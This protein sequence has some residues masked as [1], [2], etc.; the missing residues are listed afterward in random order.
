M[1][2]SA[3]RVRSSRA[4]ESNLNIAIFSSVFY[5]GFRGGG[6][7]RSLANLVLASPSG[8]RIRVF[9]RDRDFGSKER[10]EV[11]EDG[12]EQFGQAIVHY[13]RERS[14]H[15]WLGA[16][17][18]L[19]G[20]APDVI[21]VNSVWDREFC[22]LPLLLWRV[23]VLP[24]EYFLIAPRGELH[25]GA[26]QL[27]RWRKAVAGPLLAWLLKGPRVIWHATTELEGADIRS[28]APG[29]SVLVSPNLVD[30]PFVAEPPSP[31]TSATLKAVFVGRIAPKKGLLV[32]IQALAMVESPVEFDVWGPIED[33]EYWSACQRASR[34]LPSRVS[35]RYRGSASPD[36]VRSVFASRDVFIFPT[37]GENF[38]HVVAESLS[39]SCPVIVPDSTPW[40]SVLHQ[41]GGW[42]VEL[43]PAGFARAIESLANCSGVEREN[44]RRAAGL[45]YERWRAEQA[46]PHLFETLARVTGIVRGVE[47]DGG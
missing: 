10:Y 17:R 20:E 7:I 37:M 11:A 43:S 29:C 25:P 39:A 8:V 12:V 47:C 33:G 18:A 36:E 44:A 28:W 41:G 9:T 4:V 45:A 6:P 19:R 26:L 27:K 32:A 46:G 24:G 34:L 23:H 21:Y 38:G 31:S 3:K 40:S 5:P 16:C 14:W 22:W 35:L 2:L 42:V 13:M 15:H 1:V 30:L